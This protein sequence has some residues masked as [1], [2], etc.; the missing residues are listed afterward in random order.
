MK[1]I[2]YVTGSALIIVGPIG[3]DIDLH[4]AHTVV[5]SC[6]QQRASWFL[7]QTEQKLAE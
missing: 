1:C 2:C 6:G 4:K 5:M 3:N 7:D